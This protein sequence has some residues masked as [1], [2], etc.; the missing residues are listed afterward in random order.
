[1]ILHHNT[2]AHDPRLQL[3]DIACDAICQWSYEL[4]V[5]SFV[6]GHYEVAYC[7]L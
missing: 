2:I 5:L 6:M 4:F 1:M 7:L 3:D